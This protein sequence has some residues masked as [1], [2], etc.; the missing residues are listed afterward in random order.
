MDSQCIFRL[1]WDWELAGA[2]SG[3]VGTHWCSVSA[4]WARS[5]TLSVPRAQAGW[6]E[7]LCLPVKAA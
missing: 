1:D 5:G 7:V 2:V 4:Q 6:A 3:T